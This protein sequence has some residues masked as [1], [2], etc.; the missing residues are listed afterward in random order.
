LPEKVWSTWYL[1]PGKLTTWSIISHGN[2]EGQ[3]IPLFVHIAA[4]QFQVV[5]IV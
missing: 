4:C 5:M 3:Q 1:V 2:K